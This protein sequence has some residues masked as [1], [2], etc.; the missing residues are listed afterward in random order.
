MSE[1]SISK[2]L[3]KRGSCTGSVLLGD[4]EVAP[5]SQYPGGLRPAAHASRGAPPAGRE[6][7]HPHSSEKRRSGTPFPSIRRS[8]SAFMTAISVSACYRMI[9]QSTLNPVSEKKKGRLAQ[10]TNEYQQWETTLIRNAHTAK[11]APPRR[12]MAFE[13][14]PP[15]CRGGYIAYRA[16]VAA[17]AGYLL[18]AGVSSSWGGRESWFLSARSIGLSRARRNFGG[19][20][21]TRTHCWLR[22]NPP[23]I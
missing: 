4:A 1:L 5:S 9:V 19:A 3:H 21:G 18:R 6:E 23:V 20:R 16:C 15:C 7:R 14:R 22:C 17:L 13:A 2:V 8:D 10:A 11:P 12:V